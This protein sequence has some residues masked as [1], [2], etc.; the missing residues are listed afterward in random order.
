MC[1]IT[2]YESSKLFYRKSDG[3]NY[4]FMKPLTFFMTTGNVRVYLVSRSTS[5]IMSLNWKEFDAQGWQVVNSEKV[6]SELFKLLKRR[7]DA[8]RSIGEFRSY[9]NDDTI[10]TGDGGRVTL[11]DII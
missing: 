9:I 3:G 6:L 11:D 8:G 10:R 5:D 1:G 4:S 7:V 2:K